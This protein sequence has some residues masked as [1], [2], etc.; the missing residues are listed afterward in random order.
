MAFDPSVISSI[1][2]AGGDPVDAMSKGIGIADA[3]DRTQL[4]KL[5][6]GQEKRAEKEDL[7]VQEIL[8]GS[9]YT[10]PEGLA[11]TAAAAAVLRM[12]IGVSSMTRS[13][14]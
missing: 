6:L 13:F 10:T 14:Q 12:A 9:D 2:D 4:N 11:K 1:G 7:A 8:K 5:H 3:L